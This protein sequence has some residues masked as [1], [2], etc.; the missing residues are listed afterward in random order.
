MYR[1]RRDASKPRRARGLLCAS[2]AVQN[3]R[4][5]G[6]TTTK[7]Q[8]G[9][10]GVFGRPLGKWRYMVTVTWYG[11]K[12][13]KPSIEESQREQ[14]DCRSENLSCY[15]GNRSQG[16]IPTSHV[17]AEIRTTVRDLA[18]PRCQSS[19]KLAYQRIGSRRQPTNVCEGSLSLA[20]CHRR[21][22]RSYSG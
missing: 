6:Q 12:A 10:H 1:M 3:A 14:K 18:T 21:S 4:A 17:Y 5:G 8:T 9:Q 13:E 7:R 16:P 11:H 19:R 2:P 20:L 15:L 22:I